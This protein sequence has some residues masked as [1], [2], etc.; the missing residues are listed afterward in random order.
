MDN[1]KTSGVTSS[2]QSA[3]P[4]FTSPAEGAIYWHHF[5]FDVIPLFPAHKVTAVKWDAWLQGLAPEA[6]ADYWAQHPVHEVGFIVG[7][8][9]IV[10]DADSPAAVEALARIEQAHKVTPN[11]VVKTKKGEHHYFRRGLGTFARS[12][13]HSTSQ[14]PDRLDVKTGR[15]M[16]ILPPSTGKVLNVFDPKSAGDLTMVGQD[17]I[18]AIF[19]HNGRPV[20]RV[21]D[22]APAEHQDFIPSAGHMTVLNSLLGKID[23]DCGYEDWLHAGMAIYRESG[24]NEEGLELFDSWSQRGKKYGGRGEIETK[25][26]SFK[27]DPANPITVATL[28]QMVRQA[29]YDWLEVCAADEPNF[30]VIADDAIDAGVQQMA[31]PQTASNPLD[32]FSLRGMAQEIEAQAVKQIPVMGEIALKGDITVLYA[33]PN[34][35]KTL[36]SLALLTNAISSG[37]IDPSKLYYIDVDDTMNG[38]AQKLHLADEYEFHMLAEGHRGFHVGAF[39]GLL[40]ELIES[41]QAHDMIIVLDTL[42]KFAD[43]MD[44]TKASN[45]TKVARRFAMKGGTLI[46]LAHTNKHPGRDGKPIYGG[47]SDILNDIDCAYTIT[48]IDSGTAGGEKVV[49]FEKIKSRGNVVQSVAYSYG[50]LS[51]V[52]YDELL[53]SVRLVEVTQ[54]AA[55]I[56]VAQIK[57]DAEVIAAV[58]A[59]IG[60]GINTKMKL[61]EAA[62]KR[63]GVSRRNALQIIENYTGND[64]AIHRW[65][66]SVHDRGA[67]VFALLDAQ[68]QGPGSGNAPD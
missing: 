14:H 43:L 65:A 22:V 33:A 11:M 55:L 56:H 45:F 50:N 35:G 8:A 68:S 41:D 64:P 16:V 13:S 37:K 47:V 26:R 67:K 5:G 23:P 2:I 34:T 20:P 58:S 19:L 3:F 6:I 10:L 31:E 1:M 30:E 21:A 15:A 29:G 66:F 38:L 49:Q 27:S 53:A 52:S 59:C 51:N 48:T 4:Q 7:D 40:N 9:V 17:F 24:G 25:W 42:K 62:A 32:K 39:L 28:K 57:S 18:D 60:D 12:D 36:I 63:A 54:T 44:K 46:A 61:A